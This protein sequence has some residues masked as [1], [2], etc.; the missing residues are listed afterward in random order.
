VSDGAGDTCTGTVATGGCALTLATAGAKTLTASYAGD[1]NF[2]SSTSAGVAHN[3]TDFSISASPASQSLKVGQKIGYKVIL[4]AVSG[5]SGTVSLSCSALP[6]G[7]TCS[8][9][10]SSI[11]LNGSRSVNSN[12]TVQTGKSTPKATTNLTFTG[13][14]GSGVPATGGLTHNSNVSLTVN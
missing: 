14:F 3:V 10:P 8:V 12:V 2:N 6:P 1:S 13:T 9:S 7:S 11:A 5:F 4:A